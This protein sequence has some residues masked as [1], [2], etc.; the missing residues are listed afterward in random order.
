MKRAII[1]FIFL[2]L[3]IQADFTRKMLIN[4]I[5]LS[6]SDSL[7]FYSRHKYLQLPSEEG[8]NAEGWYDV[9]NDTLYL[10]QIS[11]YGM[12]PGDDPKAIFKYTFDP[13]IGLKLEEFTTPEHFPKYKI[14]KRS[15]VYRALIK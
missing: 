5:W 13:D 9:S 10:Y 1:A 2:P 8:S 15:I 11:K 14:P 6:G 4:T 7:R 3:V 12:S